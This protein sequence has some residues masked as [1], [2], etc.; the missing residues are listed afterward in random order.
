MQ[1]ELSTIHEALVKYYELKK[2]LPVVLED[3][4]KGTS[5]KNVFLKSLE[6][7]ANDEIS[8]FSK[9]EKYYLP[10][11]YDA[12]LR[13]TYKDSPHDTIIVASPRFK[14]KRYVLQLKDVINY[15][16]TQYTVT[17]DV[18]IAMDEDNFQ[19]QAKKQNWQIPIQ[20]PVNRKY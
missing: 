11:L 12:E 17:T 6:A 19:K 13:K 15:H 16:P 7:P 18:I 1:S 3:L 5:D 2:Q 14:N 8:F 10:F 20:P 9:G 4:Y